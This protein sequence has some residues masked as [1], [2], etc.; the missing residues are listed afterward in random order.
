M[1]NKHSTNENGLIG[2]TCSKCKLWYLLID[3]HKC[4]INNDGLQGM[5]K[6]CNTKKAR[7]WDVT[8][9]DRVK[10]INRKAA[11]KFR[12]SHPDYMNKYRQTPEGKTSV[13]KDSAKRRGYG[14]IFLFDNPFPEDIS[15]VGHHISDGFEVYLSKSLHMNHYGK[16]H[17]E[18]LK[19]YVES[20]YN[21]TYLIEGER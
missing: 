18:D 14:S 15:V 3:Y 9:P 7:D 17:R 11:K 4:S 2:K 10:E 5:C 12:R 16:N 20:I 6:D 8:N 21:I 19:S 13:R 1:T